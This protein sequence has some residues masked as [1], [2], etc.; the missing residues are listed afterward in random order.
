MITKNIALDSKI[1]STIATSLVASNEGKALLQV[2]PDFSAE[3]SKSD[4]NS[5]PEL[6]K[7]LHNVC[8]QTT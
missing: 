4:I 1:I 5:P 8:P 2:L 3:I 7:M 6:L